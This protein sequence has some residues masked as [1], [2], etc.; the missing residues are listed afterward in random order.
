VV[1]HLGADHCIDYRADDFEAQL[2]AAFPNGI[3]V[4][5]DGIGGQLTA[6]VAGAMNRN[7]RMFSFGGAAGFYA[8]KLGAPP[9]VRPSL[10]QNFG[11]SDKIEQIIKA[12]N[13]RSEAW[14]VD[15]FYDERLKAEGDLSRLLRRGAIKPINNVIEGFENLPQAILSLYSTSR[16]GKLQVRFEPQ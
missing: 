11:I 9:K 13:I 8:E 4:F 12:R 15:E 7:G 6:T 10:R 16:A 14:I 5:S 2:R 3:D 1:E